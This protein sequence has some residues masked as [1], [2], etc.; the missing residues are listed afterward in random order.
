MKR[1]GLLAGLSLLAISTAHAQ[2]NGVT[3]ELKLDQTE[4]LA[5]EDVP[6]KVRVSNR[7]GQ[8]ITLG[9]ENNWIVLDVS[10]QNNTPCARLGDMPVQGEFSLESGEAGTRTV[11]PTPYYDFRQLGRYRV[12]ATVRIPQWHVEIPCKPVSFTVSPGVPLPNLSN[13]QFGVP[14]APGA[15]NTTPEVRSYSLLKVS[16]FKEMKLYFRLADSRGKILRAFPIGRM[17]SFSEPEAQ[18]DR[19]NNLHVLNQNGARSFNYSVINTD[20]HWI[21]RQTYFYTGTRP[22]LRPGDDGTIIVAG[23]V[24][25]LSADDYPPP[26]PESARSQ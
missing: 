18:I 20:G 26:T 9:A 11:N 12:T 16:F 13:L 19:L 1:I 7:S 14:L 24:R 17:L 8:Q 25:R 2:I 4:F 10:D 21:E 5:D 23:G 22:V 6:L 15:T 3:A